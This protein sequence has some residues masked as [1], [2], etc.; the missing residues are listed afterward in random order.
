MSAT[1][2]HELCFLTTNMYKPPK[3]FDSPE[4]EQPLRFV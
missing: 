2:D 1:A 4:T 3:N